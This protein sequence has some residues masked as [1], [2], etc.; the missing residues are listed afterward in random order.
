MKKYK[1]LI[2]TLLAIFCTAN[3]QIIVSNPAGSEVHYDTYAGITYLVVFDHIT[4]QSQIEYTGAGTTFEWYKFS[5]PAISISNQNYISPDGAT[6]YS[7]KIDGAQEITFWVIDYSQI[8]PQINNVTFNPNDANACEHVVLNFFGNIPP[9]RYQD[10]NGEI[11]NINRN[12]SVTYTTQSWGTDAW[13]TADTTAVTVLNGNNSAQIPA[14]LVNTNFS[15][16][17]SDP[18]ANDLGITPATVQSVTY[19]AI[20]VKNKLITETTTRDAAN[21]HQRPDNKNFLEGSAP[22]D[23]HFIGNPTAAVAHNQW[24]V[25]KENIF[26]FTRTAADFRYTFND[27]GQ[28]K[29]VLVSSNQQCSYTDS[30]NVK[31]NESALEVPNVFTPNGDGINDEFRVAY[32][33]LRSFQMAVYN[34][35]G[36]KIF[37]T[38]DPQRGWNGKIGQRDAAAGPYFYYIKATGTDGR[39]Y[40]LKGDINLIR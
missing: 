27:Y 34:R 18:F 39:K 15:A 32:R 37:E 29:I 35:W 16:T 25:F 14:P 40:V 20:A 2:F 26:F 28:Y 21:E 24:T 9:L 17:I 3:A 19:Q 8:M 11:H 12:V 13:I 33:S 6:G 30:V 5:N 36:N 4:A 38:N 10:K 1:I 31:I 22:L 23:I 7:L